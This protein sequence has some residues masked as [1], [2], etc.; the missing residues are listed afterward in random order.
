MPTYVPEYAPKKLD[1]KVRQKTIRFIEWKFL[2]LDATPLDEWTPRHVQEWADYLCVFY[3]Q[4]IAISKAEKRRQERVAG[5][6]DYAL[7]RRTTKNS[8]EGRL[9]NRAD[10]DERVRQARP[11]WASTEA[12]VDI[13]AQAY[14]ISRD[15]GIPH[16]VDH[17]VPL[18]GKWRGQHVVCGL[19]CEA[20]LIIR[21]ATDN[22]KKGCTFNPST[23]K[24]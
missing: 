23:Y 5:C 1:Y 19:H 4:R 17:D 14:R 18:V 2:V 9:K 15:T 24:G 13:Y 16:H 11:A 8:P 3:D 22:L 20:N 12:M 21:P 6:P 7:N 10:R